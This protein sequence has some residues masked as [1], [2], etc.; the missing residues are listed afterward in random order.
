MSQQCMITQ[1]ILLVLILWILWKQ[2]AKERLNSYV[3]S[4]VNSQVFTSGA[5]MRRLAQEFSQP[6][7]GKRITIHNAELKPGEPPKFDVI[8]TLAPA[9]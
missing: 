8:A 9:N 4:G 2:Y 5:T 7:Q 6:G 1:A 3:G